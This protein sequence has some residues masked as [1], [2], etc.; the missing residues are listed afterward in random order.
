MEEMF[1]CNVVKSH[2]SAGN[3]GINTNYSYA[4]EKREGTTN[5]TQNTL[6]LEVFAMAC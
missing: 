6:I 5:L 2:L 4:V 1:I 3:D